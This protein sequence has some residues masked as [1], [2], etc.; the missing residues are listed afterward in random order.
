MNAPTKSPIIQSSGQRPQTLS[1]AAIIAASPDPVAA[2]FQLGEALAK[3]G[4][5]GACDRKE[6]G[7]AAV[8][9]ICEGGATVS[10]FNRRF[11]LTFGKF[12]LRIGAAVADF[13]ARGGTITWLADGSD[14]KQAR[15]RFTL[16][17]ESVEVG[18]TVEEAQKAGWTRNKKWETETQSMLRARV[19]KRGITELAPDI[20]Y[21]EGDEPEGE[22]IE[23]DRS[24][25]VQAAA[26]AATPAPT[27]ALVVAPVAAP[28]PAPMP[29]PAPVNPVAPAVTH[30]PSSPV[31]ELPVDVQEKLVA[32]IGA[33]RLGHAQAWM[34]SV[35]WLKS[36]Q[37]IEEISLAN[38]NA[39]IG[40]AD[41]FN[42][43][44]DE[45][46]A[47]GGQK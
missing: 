46:I 15:A 47:N 6:Q 10:N 2:L 30:A 12:E 45:F 27:P 14:N 37:S 18:C 38:A 41:R 11:Q 32:A 34:L 21:G 35:G 13:K 26:K 19:K 25:M 42:A 3:S 16:G 7:I 24:Q 8:A 5:L 31:S 29:T 40:R 39:I 28:S 1:L 22:P 44:L 23:I 36:G 43:K 17:D 33:D 20:Y 9:R 4:E